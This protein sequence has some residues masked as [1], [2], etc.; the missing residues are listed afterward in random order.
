MHLP[1]LFKTKLFG[2]EQVLMHI[3]LFTSEAFPHA[4]GQYFKTRIIVLFKLSFLVW[5]WSNGHARSADS[6]CKS[7]SSS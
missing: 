2:Q 7:S 3:G 5:S 4:F 6:T 1:S